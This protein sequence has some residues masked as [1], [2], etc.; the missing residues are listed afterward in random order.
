MES[1]LTELI[2][3]FQ[4]DLELQSKS[5]RRICSYVNTVRYLVPIFDELGLEFST[6][7]IHRPQ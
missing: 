2:E 5:H 3:E 4:Q 7:D 1:Q 6:V